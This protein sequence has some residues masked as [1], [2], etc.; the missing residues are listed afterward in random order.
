MRVSIYKI[1]DEIFA[2]T[3]EQGAFDSWRSY[4]GKSVQKNRYVES[5]RDRV[6]PFYALFLATFEVGFFGSG[7]QYNE[8]GDL[9][10]SVSSALF[11]HN[12]GAADIKGKRVDV[13]VRGREIQIGQEHTYMLPENGGLRRLDV[14]ENNTAGNEV[15]IEVG[16]DSALDV[17]AAAILRFRHAPPKPAPFYWKECGA[18]F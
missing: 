14:A 9:V 4:S 8:V 2:L 13:L 16:F 6:V 18:F 1:L 5:D 17:V 7:L 3:D 11:D 12:S 10:K 15:W